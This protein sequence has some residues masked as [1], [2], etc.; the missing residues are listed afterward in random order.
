MSCLCSSQGDAELLTELDSVLLARPVYHL[1]KWSDSLQS[2]ITNHSSDNWEDIKEEMMVSNVL[3]RDNVVFAKKLHPQLET[4]ARISD[5][6]VRL[7]SA[8]SN[9]SKSI[10]DQLYV[11]LIN[12][13]LYVCKQ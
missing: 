8:N 6:N 13:V 7:L 3:Q 4:E 2:G 9:S 11:Q 5:Q 10:F 12:I 1:G